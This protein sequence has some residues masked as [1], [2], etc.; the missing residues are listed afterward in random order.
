MGSLEHRDVGIVG[1][2]RGD[3]A[4]E[5]DC[6]KLLVGVVTEEDTGHTSIICAKKAYREAGFDDDIAEEDH[7][8]ISGSYVDGSGLLFG[9]LEEKDDL[10]NGGHPC[11][12]AVTRRGKDRW[13]SGG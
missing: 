11:G 10:G 2:E 9:C 3:H 13:K 4:V 7:V 1:S 5:G 6:V 8:V 12:K